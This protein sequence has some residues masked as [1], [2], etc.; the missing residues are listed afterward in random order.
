MFVGRYYHTLE[1]KGRLSLP[2]EFRTQTKKWVVT[3]GLDGGLFLM[4]AS[5]FQANLAKFAKRTFTKK[6]N[7]DFIRLMTNDAK[8][9]EPDKLGRVTLPA[10][11][12]KLAGLKKQVVVVGSYNYIE[13]WDQAKYHK[14]LEKL[15]KEAEKI[16]ERLPDDTD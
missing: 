5:D 7:R 4:K 12:T 8:L 10:Y 11:L 1:E 2:K 9:V 15:E 13:I 6:A 16:A 3:R 14:Y